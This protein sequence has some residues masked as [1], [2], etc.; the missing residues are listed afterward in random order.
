MRDIPKR[1]SLTLQLQM[2][3][4]NIGSGLQ[5]QSLFMRNT[6]FTILLMLF[7]GVIDIASFNLVLVLV[8]WVSGFNV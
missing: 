5:P 4:S 2:N 8:V 3:F 6:F 7:N 1:I